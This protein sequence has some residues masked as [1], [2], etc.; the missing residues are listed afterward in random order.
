LALFGQLKRIVSNGSIPVCLAKEHLPWQLMYQELADM[1]CNRITTRHHTSSSARADQ[2]ALIPTT[3]R[4]DPQC[5]FKIRRAR[6][7][8]ETTRPAP[9]NQVNWVISTANGTRSSAE[10]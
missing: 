10:W 4:F 8:G 9:K 6:S 5:R 7:T 3:H 2:G 1:A